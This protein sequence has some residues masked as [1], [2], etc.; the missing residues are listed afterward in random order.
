MSGHYVTIISL[1]HDKNV[2]G[3]VT[4]PPFTFDSQGMDL[5]FL[6]RCIGVADH[7]PLDQGVSM[8]Q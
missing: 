3:G 7:F 5:P 1:C 6:I 4:F 8:P 2:I